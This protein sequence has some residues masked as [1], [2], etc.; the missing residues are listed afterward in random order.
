MCTTFRYHDC[1]RCNHI[2]PHTIMHK[3]SSIH[4]VH[5]YTK[6]EG[7]QHIKSNKMHEIKPVKNKR[8]EKKEQQEKT[9]HIRVPNT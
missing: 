9:Y 7:K 2:V 4:S 5:F 6:R 3:Y 8:V 1:Q